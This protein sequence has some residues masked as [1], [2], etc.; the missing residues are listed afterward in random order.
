MS[1]KYDLT[2]YQNR[3]KNDLAPMR[4]DSD[5]TG[6]V[7]RGPGTL[8]QQWQK[9]WQS[10]ENHVSEQLGE[11]PPK[12]IASLRLGKQYVSRH[13]DLFRTCMGDGC[14]RLIPA[15]SLDVGDPRFCKDCDPTR[16]EIILKISQSFV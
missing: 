10:G 9:G 12:T 13:N 7:E 2:V 6:H 4:G 16:P 8:C 1:I 3:L 14:R 15:D 5:A 11:T